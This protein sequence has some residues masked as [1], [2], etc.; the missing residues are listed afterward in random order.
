MK[1]MEESEEDIGKMRGMG[2]QQK[3]NLIQDVPFGF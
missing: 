2:E 3:G 1:Y